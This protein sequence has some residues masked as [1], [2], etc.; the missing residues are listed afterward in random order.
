MTNKDSKN[1]VPFTQVKDEALIAKLLDTLG[2]HKLPMTFWFKEQSLRFESEVFQYLQHL[3]KLMIKLPTDIGAD[4][5]SQA[6]QA[7][8]TPQIFSSFQVDTVNYFFKTDVLELMAPDAFRVEIPK[9]V[10]KLQRRANLRIPF[11]RHEAPRVTCIHPKSM[12]KKTIND[13]DIL[14][15][16]ML[17]LS[18]GGIAVAAPLETKDDL[19]LG[20]IIKDLR[21]NLKGNEISCTAVV[22]HH[23]DAENDQGKPIIRVGL[24]FTA[25]RPQFERVIAQ[26]V[27]DESRRMFSILY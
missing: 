23:K 19:P 16:R 21:F 3:K 7:Q 2:K 12:D 13:S 8:G 10:F 27:M 26:Y 4:A 9:E 18:A 15:F 6:I 17:D 1:E 24:Q 20:K 5:F 11:K 25:L 14:Q 22:R